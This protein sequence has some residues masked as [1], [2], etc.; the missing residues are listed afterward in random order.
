MSNID[1][2][3]GGN[4]HGIMIPCGSYMNRKYK[5]LELILL[6]LRRQTLFSGDQFCSDKGF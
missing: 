6:N 3:A 5:R 2:A 4:K 1:K